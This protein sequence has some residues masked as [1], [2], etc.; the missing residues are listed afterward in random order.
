MYYEL[1]KFFKSFYD[2][3]WFLIIYVFIGNYD[4][5]DKYLCVVNSMEIVG[6]VFIC[7]CVYF[8]IMCMIID[9]VLCIFVLFYED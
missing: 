9:D 4:M 3:I 6:F 7:L 2:V 8:E 5:F 1:V